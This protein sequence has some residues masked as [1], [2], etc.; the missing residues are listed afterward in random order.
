MVKQR[1]RFSYTAE[2][3]VVI[4]TD[5]QISNFGSLFVSRS[6]SLSHSLFLPHNFQSAAVWHLKAPLVLNAPAASVKSYARVWQNPEM[7]HALYEMFVFFQAIKKKNPTFHT[8]SILEQRWVC[9]VQGQ[10]LLTRNWWHSGAVVS[11]VTSQQEGRGFDSC[12]VHVLPVPVWVLSGY[13][14]FL[15]RSKNMQTGG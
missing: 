13:S 10:Q 1:A 9:S 2:Y 7:E 15:S 8:Y 11:T 14:G 5:C 4:E 12:R 6:L 3:V